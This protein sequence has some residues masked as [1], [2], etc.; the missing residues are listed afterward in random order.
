MKKYRTKGCS[1]EHLLSPWETRLENKDS[2]RTALLGSRAG[3]GNVH[4]LTQILKPVRSLPRLISGADGSDS[5][6]QTLVVTKPTRLVR[7]HPSG[8]PHT[9]LLNVEDRFGR[10]EA[11]MNF[12]YAKCHGMPPTTRTLTLCETN[13]STLAEKDLEFQSIY[14]DANLKIKQP[15]PPPPQQQQQQQQQRGI[16]QRLMTVETMARDTA[17]DEL[18]ARELGPTKFMEGCADLLPGIVDQGKNS[19]VVIL[20][21]KRLDRGCCRGASATAQRSLLVISVL[22][23]PDANDACI[24]RQKLRQPSND[25]TKYSSHRKGAQPATFERSRSIPWYLATGAT[26]LMLHR[27]S[28]PTIPRL[29]VS[30]TRLAQAASGCAPSVEVLPICDV[31]ANK[32]KCGN[33]AKM[34]APTSLAGSYTS[35]CDIT[36]CQ[37]I[38]S[39]SEEVHFVRCGK[40]GNHLGFGLVRFFMNSKHIC[41]INAC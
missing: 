5:L 31:A 6:P 7:T 18:I 29:R 9:L 37:R 13:S 17:V 41:S 10:P 20:K 15:P 2:G 22:I 24:A 19:F 14:I 36:F 33:T 25:E 40:D 4:M 32:A 23:T 12:R 11:N 3:H 27:C 34:R 26:G 1:D 35:I 21:F 16:K 38:Y 8:V 39:S 28:D 30:N